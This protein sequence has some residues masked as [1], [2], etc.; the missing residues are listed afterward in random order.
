MYD[1]ELV[2]NVYV[3]ERNRIARVNVLPN[4]TT[5]LTWRAR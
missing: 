1:I 2:V 5:Y 3:F 4:V